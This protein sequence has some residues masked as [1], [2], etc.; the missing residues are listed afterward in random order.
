M[1]VLG[2]VYIKRLIGPI[3]SGSCD[4][5]TLHTKVLGYLLVLTL[6]PFFFN[7]LNIFVST[8][9]MRY[10]LQ[11]TI[12]IKFLYIYDILHLVLVTVRYFRAKI[13]LL[14]WSFM[15]FITQVFHVI[16]CYYNVGL[17]LISTP[18]NVKPPS[19]KH[20]LKN[21]NIKPLSNIEAFESSNSLVTQ[22]ILMYIIEM[23]A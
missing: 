19:N 18:Y 10:Q 17:P 14:I 21:Q 2:H 12:S 20:P 5:V 7:R 8:M 22:A 16:P 23:C 4:L 1:P 3:T 9:R 13:T 6:L 15:L 11:E